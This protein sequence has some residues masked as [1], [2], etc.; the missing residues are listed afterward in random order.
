MISFFHKSESPLIQNYLATTKRGLSRKTPLMSNRFVVIDT[1]TSG[2][3]VGTDRILSIAIFEIV[4]GQIDMALC[5][6]WTVFQP[7]S[8]LTAATAIHGILPSE[9]REGM[10]EKKVLEELIPLL[11][12]AVVVGHHIRFDAAMI[13]EAMARHFRAKFINRT[14]DTAVMAMQELVAFHQT[15]YENQRPP[16]L[17]EVC[18]QLSLPIVARHTAEGDAFL[19]AQIFLFLCGRIRRR[20][21]RRPVNRRP[22]K[23]RDLAAKRFRE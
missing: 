16:S 20:L 21:L 18:S 17:D 11:T 9:T 6:K 22:P 15:G 1:E 10:H 13:S 23:L 19:A 5:R 4:N 8:A 7:E 3:N 12:G 2:F 14:V